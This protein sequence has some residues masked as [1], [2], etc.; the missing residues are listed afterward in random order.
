[1][2]TLIEVLI[3]EKTAIPDRFGFT[4]LFRLAYDIKYSFGNEDIDIFFNQFVIFDF[5][6]MDADDIS[7]LAAFLI[8]CNAFKNEYQVSKILKKWYLKIEDKDK[9]SELFVILA[10]FSKGLISNELTDRHAKIVQ[11]SNP[12]LWIEGIINSKW[13]GLLPDSSI[14]DIGRTFCL[15]LDKNDF[16]SEFLTY[17]SLLSKSLND[18]YEK[19]NFLNI[20]T[21]CIDNCSKQS[22]KNEINSWLMKKNIKLPSAQP[23]ERSISDTFKSLADKAVSKACPLHK[24]A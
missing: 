9:K 4:P 17:M 24:V 12:L 11:E 23:I 18:K 21:Y 1:M 20:V 7:N 5:E 22:S 2:D 8:E 13:F 19:A 15:I 16:D 10:R 6:K 14:I 3:N